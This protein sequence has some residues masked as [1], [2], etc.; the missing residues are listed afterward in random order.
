VVI[1]LPL[2]LYA[3]A[4]S[5]LIAIPG[6][7]SCRGPRGN[8]AADVGHGRHPARRRDPQFLVRDDLLVLVF[9]VNLRWF[10]AGGFP[11][12]DAG[13]WPA[14]KALTCRRSRWPAAGG[15][16]GPGHALRADRHAR[17]GFHPHRPRQGADPRPGAAGAMR[18]ATR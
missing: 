14:M 2:T 4:L 18:C 9:A 7:N 16:P 5:T 11:G 10:S 13:F 8:S 12:W 15:D 6:W 3:L 1:S 17:R